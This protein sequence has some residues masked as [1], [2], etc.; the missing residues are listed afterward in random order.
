MV[1]GDCSASEVSRN[2]Y[3]HVQKLLREAGLTESF[4]FTGYRSDALRLLAAFDI[5]A[6]STNFEG[7]PLA[8][9]EAMAYAKPVVATA[10]DGIP[11]LIT[12]GVDG[13]LTP[14]ADAQVLSAK[15]LAFLNEPVLAARLGTAARQT[16]L[17]NFTAEHFARRMMDLYT[18]LLK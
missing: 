8:L 18:R 4:I 10:V 7:L 16:V 17:Q 14:H 9:V 1:A 15:L 3:A 12:D 5:V 11:E 13:F 2:H 6:L